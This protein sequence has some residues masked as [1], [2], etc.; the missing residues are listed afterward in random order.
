[1]RFNAEY[2]KNAEER[3][4]KNSKGNGENSFGVPASAG[5]GRVNADLPTCFAA[6]EPGA[7]TAAKKSR[8]FFIHR[9]EQVVVCAME[10][11]RFPRFC[12]GTSFQQLF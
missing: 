11:R 2:A 12:L 10:T 6:R 9:G 8:C 3:R 4:G 7:A 1:M 5:P